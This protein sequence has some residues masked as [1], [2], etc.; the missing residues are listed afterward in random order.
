[1]CVCVCACVCVLARTQRE[2]RWPNHS[3]GSYGL[4]P[5]RV[6]VNPRVMH[7]R[8]VVHL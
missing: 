2:Y 5:W 7:V 4:S 8:F 3:V 1:V 6:R